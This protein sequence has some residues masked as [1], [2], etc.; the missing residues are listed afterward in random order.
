MTGYDPNAARMQSFTGYTAPYNY[1]VSPE[2][3]SLSQ[4]VTIDP[5]LM[6]V[7]GIK[8]GGV[9][10]ANVPAFN[11]PLGYTSLS[12]AGGFGNYLGA[13]AGL[14]KTGAGLLMG[15]INAYTGLK[16]LSLAKDAFRQQKKEFNINL[17]NQ[18]QSYNTQV[19]DRIA[20]RYYATEAERQAALAAATLTDRSSYG[21]GG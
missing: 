21:K 4:P 2:L 10:S 17:A 18:T 11:N 8:F 7:S 12:E 9:G 3:T 19:G 20:G 1:G 15:G 5:G 6:D 16:G 13:N 14:F